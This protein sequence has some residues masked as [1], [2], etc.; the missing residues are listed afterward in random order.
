MQYRKGRHLQEFQM[1]ATTKDT[2][3]APSFNKSGAK[4]ARA[5]QAL[6]KASE[7]FRDSMTIAFQS[8]IDQC[9]IAG[10]PRNQDSCNAIRKAI[11]LA[12]DEGTGALATG[13]ALN[14]VERKTI[15]EYGN[16]AQRAFFH[17]VPWSPTLKNDPAYALPW[18]KAKATKEGVTVEAKKAGAVSTTSVKDLEQTILKAIEQARMLQMRDFANELGGFVS[19]YLD[20][21]KFESKSE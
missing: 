9:V 15:V 18:G 1:P 5:F 2:I 19:T 14:Y 4:I 20:S 8:Y 17:G 21:F 10:M 16:G 13:V 6:D 7:D 11:A 3:K 12:C